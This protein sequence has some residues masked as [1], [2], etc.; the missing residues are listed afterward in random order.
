IELIATEL[1][2]Y[3]QILTK[4][5]LKKVASSEEEHYL[6]IKK[7]IKWA[8][9]IVLE[10]SHESFQV[11][12]EATIAMLDKKRVLGLSIYRDWSK[13]IINDYFHGAKYNEYNIR[14]VINDFL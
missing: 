12:H 10:L 4:S 1:G 7:G 6:A 14:S 8:D 9:L 13:N 3:K 5:D 2:N 11:G